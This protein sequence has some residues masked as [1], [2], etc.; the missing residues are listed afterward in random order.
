MDISKNTLET[1]RKE[2][3]VKIARKDKEKVHLVETMASAE[4]AY[5]ALEKAKLKIESLKDKEQLTKIRFVVKN[6]SEFGEQIGKIYENVQQ[7]K[8]K[9]VISLAKN[10][11]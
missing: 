8:Y 6:C 3:I 11:R 10:I 9:E 1:E 7:Y 2:L 4:E 5:V